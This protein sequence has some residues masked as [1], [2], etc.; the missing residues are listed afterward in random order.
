MCCI[1]ESEQPAIAAVVAAPIR[2]EWEENFAANISLYDMHLFIMALNS[3]LVR[4]SEPYEQKKA[5]PLPGRI[6]KYLRTAF[7]GQ[8]PASISCIEMVQPFPLGSV[9]DSLKESFTRRCGA[10]PAG[11]CHVRET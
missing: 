11:D 3:C 9:F 10:L 5:S 2:K 1:W 4:G 7:T 6:Y 8:L